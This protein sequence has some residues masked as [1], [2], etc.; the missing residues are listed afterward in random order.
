MMDVPTH[1]KIWHIR[2]LAVKHFK[3]ICHLATT[4]DQTVCGAEQKIVDL[5]GG[6]LLKYSEKELKIENFLLIKSVFSSP[7]KIAAKR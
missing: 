5:N 7:A 3:V 1:S 2:N 4:G 6:R